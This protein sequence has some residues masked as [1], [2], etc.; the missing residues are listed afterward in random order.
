MS[1]D[2]IFARLSATNSK[3]ES[4]LSNEGNDA[5]ILTVPSKPYDLVEVS[6]SRTI[7][8]LGLSWTAPTD[9]GGSPILDYNVITAV[10]T[11]TT[12]DTSYT[13]EGLTAGVEYTFTVTAR[14][15]FGSSLE[16]DPLAL[17]C[18]I[19][20]VAPTSVSTAIEGDYVRV[21]WDL[22]TDNGSAVTSYLV[23][24]LEI[25]TTTYTAE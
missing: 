16:S 4:P 18:A 6:A 8:T 3:G 13:V 5:I 24:L 25:G 1:G 15:Q 23:Y 14:N 10:G 20:P 9:N 2:S 17:V 7:S 22:T 19:E 12:S 11:F 21:S